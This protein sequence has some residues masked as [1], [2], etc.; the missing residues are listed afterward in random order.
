[1]IKIDRIKVHLS[2][3][4]DD[5][6]VIGNAMASGC[7]K[8]DKACEDAILARI[9]QDDYWAWALVSVHVS[10]DLGGVTVESEKEYLGNCC[11]KDEEDFKEHSGYYV[12]M[13]ETAKEDLTSKLAAL[14]VALD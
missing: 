14:K 2:H 3:E 1:M 6:P 8:M 10:L 12:D 11:Y 7:D 5:T 9:E 4:L 13:V